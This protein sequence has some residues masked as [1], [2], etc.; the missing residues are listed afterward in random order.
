[1]QIAGPLS[2][3]PLRASTSVPATATPRS[4]PA[5][6]GEDHRSHPVLD[7]AEA[8]SSRVLRVRPTSG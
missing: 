7:N 6:V 1:M 5:R 2:S 3:W 8:I 4:I